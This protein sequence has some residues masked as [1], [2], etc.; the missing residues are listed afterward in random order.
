MRS[1]AFQ[2]RAMKASIHFIIISV[3]LTLLA[4]PSPG[5]N[6]AATRPLPY[7]PDPSDP[8]Q[9]AR[10]LQT[11]PA[12]TSGTHS[13]HPRQ[14]DYVSATTCWGTPSLSRKESANAL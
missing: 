1:E 8:W 13:S 3:T 6:G 14:V 4:S 7:T 10:P 11:S 9:G 12:V 2:F 5:P